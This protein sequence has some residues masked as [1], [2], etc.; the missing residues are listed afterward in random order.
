MAA[1]VVS[2]RCQVCNKPHC[3]SAIVIG[4]SGILG[5]Y[6]SKLSMLK[7]PFIWT[8]IMTETA[9]AITPKSLGKEKVGQYLYDRLAKHVD[10]SVARRDL[11][12]AG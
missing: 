6:K 5:A 7:P 12:K 11:P 9:S 4:A 10:E 1:H 2:A 8:I 3:R